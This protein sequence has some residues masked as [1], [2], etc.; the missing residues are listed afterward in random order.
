MAANIFPH[1]FFPCTHQQQQPVK[2][3]TDENMEYSNSNNDRDNHPNGPTSDDTDKNENN[4]LP[5]MDEVDSDADTDDGGGCE[6]GTTEGGEE[7]EEEEEEGGDEKEKAVDGE[8]HLKGPTPTRRELGVRSPSQRPTKRKRTDERSA[9]GQRDRAPTSAGSFLAYVITT[10]NQRETCVECES[11]DDLV[12]ELRL[13]AHP[14]AYS[15]AVVDNAWRDARM[16]TEERDA[17]HL[18]FGMS[19]QGYLAKFCH[20]MV[21][22]PGHPELGKCRFCSAFIRYS[23]HMA[24]HVSCYQLCD[25]LL[26]EDACEC[27]RRRTR[28]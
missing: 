22:V 14:S 16:T 17:I 28:S 25:K 13:P 18:T 7:E 5:R 19:V 2:T 15:I 8:F 23:S 27:E 20:H 26:A 12:Y 4:P 3:T 11:F 10:Y 24:K 1:F 6:T 21:V 9:R